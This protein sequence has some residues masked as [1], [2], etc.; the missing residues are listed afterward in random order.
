MPREMTVRN[1][2][3]CPPPLTLSPDATLSETLSLMIQREVNHIPLCDDDGRFVGLVSSNALL[4]VLMPGD[5]APANESDEVALGHLIGRL[6]DSGHR[7]VGDLVDTNVHPVALDTPILE[8]A[9]R[10]SDTPAPL[11]VVNR[12]GH[13]VGL[14]GRR[15]LLT[16]LIDKGR[17][18]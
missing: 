10:L 5:T 18:H 11:P 17:P 1:L 4:R 16:Y 15:L 14:L 6:H 12:A 3:L 7:C 9:R 2:L 8:A 13:L